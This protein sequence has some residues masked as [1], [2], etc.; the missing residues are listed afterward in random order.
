M[1]K[2]IGNANTLMKRLTFFDLRYFIDKHLLTFF[3][4]YKSK[5]TPMDGLDKS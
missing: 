5:N 4:L 1:Y 2:I 3:K